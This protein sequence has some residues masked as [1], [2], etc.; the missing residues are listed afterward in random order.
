MPPFRIMALSAMVTVALL[1]GCSPDKSV[2]PQ[3]ASPASASTTAAASNS[4]ALDTAVDGFLSGFFQ[5]NPV[6]AANA[7]KHEF[8]GKLPD[9]SAEGL[10]ATADW[11]H[12]QR[13]KFAAFTDDHL[14]VQGRYHRDYVLAVIDG[15]LL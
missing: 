8:D 5:H 2:P 4:A 11:L 15:Q 6:F 3:P 7:G 9:Y 10:K 14:D 13:D 12:A 1:A